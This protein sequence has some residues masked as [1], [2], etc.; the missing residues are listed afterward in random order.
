LTVSKGCVAV[1]APQAARPP[2]MNAPVVVDMFA[3]LFPPSLLLS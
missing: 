3:L 1:T 2:A